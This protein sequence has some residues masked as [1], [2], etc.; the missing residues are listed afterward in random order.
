MP[1]TIRKAGDTPD[2][3]AYW[4]F[5]DIAW[6]LR[7]VRSSGQSGSQLDGRRRQNL[8]DKQKFGG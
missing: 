8:T 4:Y 7:D 3:F 2:Q 1:L 5:S 6:M